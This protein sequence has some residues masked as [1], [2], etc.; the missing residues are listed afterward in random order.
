MDIVCHVYRLNTEGPQSEMMEHESEDGLLSAANH[1]ILPSQDL[2]G[3]W[4]SLIYDSTIKDNVR[5]TEDRL[6]NG[7]F[8]KSTVFW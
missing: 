2:H 6:A 3:L 5:S 8:L 7:K 1:W 4:E